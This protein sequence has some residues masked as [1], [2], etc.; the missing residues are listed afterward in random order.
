VERRDRRFALGLQWHPEYRINPEES[1][2][3]QAFVDAARS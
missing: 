2:L 3:F 1:R